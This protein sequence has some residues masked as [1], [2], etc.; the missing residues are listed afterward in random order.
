MHVNSLQQRW[1]YGS[2]TPKQLCFDMAW[3]LKRKWFVILFAVLLA[4]NKYNLLIFESQPHHQTRGKLASV[5][6]N[7]NGQLLK[8][9]PTARICFHIHN[10]KRMTGGVFNVGIPV[11]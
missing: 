11:L 2:S 6:Q 10:A 3:P 5:I 4:K 1:G 8:P 7:C 9:S